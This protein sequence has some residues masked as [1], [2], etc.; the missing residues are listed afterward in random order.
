MIPCHVSHSVA[1]LDG[2]KVLTS[3]DI[4][5]DATATDRTKVDKLITA[6]L[7]PN[8]QTTLHPSI[9]PLP[10]TNFSSLIQ[11]ELDRKAANLPLTGGI[12]L[13]RYEAPDPPSTTQTSESENSEISKEWKKTLR[14]AY[15]SSS[16]LSTRLANL[17]LLDTYGKNAW[18]IGNSQLE[19]I[20]KNLERELVEIRDA[21][22]Q[23]NGARKSVQEDSRGEIEGLEQTWRRGV[24]RILEIEVAAEG[25]RRDILEL[26]R[27]QSR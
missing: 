6:E 15:A 12:D 14:K 19:D 17:T 26:R 21:T 13:S 4:D 2:F 1:Y 5:G 24:G 16:Y 8:Y 25:L 3:P 11:Q 27:Q 23:V 18:L 9:P 10:K 7:P 22:D 20:L